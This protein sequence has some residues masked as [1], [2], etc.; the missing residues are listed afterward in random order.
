M[1]LKEKRNGPLVNLKCIVATV[2]C[3]VDTAETTCPARQSAPTWQG[4]Q[5]HAV[6]GAIHGTS[7][8]GRRLVVCTAALGLTT[9]VWTWEFVH[10]YMHELGE[11]AMFMLEVLHAGAALHDAAHATTAQATSQ[12]PKASNAHPSRTPL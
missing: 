8:T 10:A 7:L 11:G 9:R 12:S 1:R 3:T 4:L 6:K 5:A 2:A